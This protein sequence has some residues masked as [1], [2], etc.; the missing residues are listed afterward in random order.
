MIGLQLSQTHYTARY[1]TSLKHLKNDEILKVPEHRTKV[2][3]I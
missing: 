3:R 2:L 1:Q